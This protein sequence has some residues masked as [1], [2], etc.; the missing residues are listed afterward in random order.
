M[1]LFDPGAV[2]KQ[3][4]AYLASVPPGKRLLLIGSAD[5]MSKKASASIVLK[6]SDSVGAYVRVSKTVGGVTEAD[7]GVKIALLV[8]MPGQDTP[9]PEEPFTY[10]ELVAVFKDRGLGWVRSH[11]YAYRVVNGGTVEL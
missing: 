5:L 2:N 8:D 6:V 9:D 4:D 7:A 10:A 3:I 11:L 1:G